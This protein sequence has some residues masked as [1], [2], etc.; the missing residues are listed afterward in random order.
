MTLKYVLKIKGGA[1]KNGTCEQGLITDRIRS[2][3]EGTVFTGVCHSLHRQGGGWDQGVC[4]CVTGG[5]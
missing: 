3:T 4:V 5:M 1:D 2:M